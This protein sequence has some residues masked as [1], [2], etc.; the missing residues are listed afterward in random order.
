MFCVC[1]VVVCKGI[2]TV[3]GLLFPKQLMGMAR[4][5]RNEALRP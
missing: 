4:V 5:V 3:H 2:L 1:E